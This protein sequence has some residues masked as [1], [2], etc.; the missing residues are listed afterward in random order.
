MKATDYIVEFLIEKKIGHVFGYPG[1]MVTHLM[2]SL[3]KAA[4][5]ISAHVSYNEQGAALAA[6]GYAQAAGVPGCAYATS[7]PGVTNLV[8]GI[9]N[10]FYDSVPVIFIT[11][12]VN[13]YE[14]KDNRGIRQRG[15]QEMDVVS[16]VESISKYSVQIR[17]EEEL[18]YHLE[19]AFHLATSGRPGPVVLDIPMNIQR[20]EI[21]PAQLKGF[22][23]PAEAGELKAEELA[24]I[25][26]LLSA[27][28]R[29]CIIAGAGVMA[30][31][32]GEVFAKLAQQLQIPVVTSMLAVDLLPN[33]PYGFGFIG[34]YGMRYANWIPA[35]SDVILA[36]GTR[37][38]LRQIG[39]ERAKF[40]P[41]AKLIRI[42]VDQAELEYPV[43]ENEYGYLA[44]LRQCLPQM[45]AALPS[46]LRPEWLEQCNQWKQKLD[47]WDT[48][49][50]QQW[51]AELG[52][53]L[54]APAM[55]TT[56]VGQNQVW[57]AQSL[58]V[59]QGQ[60]VLFSGG[61]GAMGYSLPAAIGACLASGKPTYC[62]TGD[63]GLM[64]NI[65]ELQWV[66]R[67]QLPIK[68]LLLN[69]T[70]L[71]MI[72]HFQEMYFESNFSQ[73]KAEKGYTVP[74][75]EKVAAGFGIA[76]QKATSLEQLSQLEGRFTDD[77][78]FFLEMVLQDNT[79]VFPKSSVT[80]SIWQQEP[81]LPGELQ[82]EIDQW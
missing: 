36:L 6:C 34:A 13:T 77:A 1:G 49:P 10:A 12:Q 81:E 18:R 28:K 39:I 14:S 41:D 74:S 66:A 26:N 46:C 56:D 48:Q 65:Q 30:S 23:P 32:Q 22:V 75:F 52:K 44:N 62:F 27:A 82:I 57:V 47:G 7:G 35:K 76:Y 15:F 69:N 60:R 31:G 78:P 53:Y 58:A 61:H 33:S 72:R 73:T 67:E 5:R 21:D 3:D 50:P 19:K 42:D 37:L 51:V 29:P 2:D 55:I 59:K 68:I 64:M 38:D 54:Q 80:K 45:V 20:A 70:S 4:G 11:G 40:A 79:Y 71:G 8:T 16:I 43:K 25:A 9:A 63:G 17:Q 24:Q